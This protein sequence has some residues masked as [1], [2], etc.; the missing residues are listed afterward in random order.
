VT[1]SSSLHTH[2]VVVNGKTYKTS[3]S[4][5]THTETPVPSTGVVKAFPATGTTIQFLAALADMSIDVL[6]LAA[7]TYVWSSVYINVDRTARPLIVRPA[8]GAAVAFKSSSGGLFY[9]GLGGTAKYLDFEF[10]GVTFDGY[11]L[12]STGLV[13]MGNADHITFNGPTVQNCVATGDPINSWALY[14]SVD[15]GLSPT[16][17]VADDWTVKGMSRTVSALQVG[18]PPSTLGHVYARRW[19][20]D[21]VSYAV[22]AYGTATDLQLDG[23]TVTN[24][25]RADRPYTVFFGAA[26]FGTFSNMNVGT[27]GMESQGGMVRGSGNVGI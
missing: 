23:W 27:G 16:N 12:G 22:Y 26:C 10:A 2:T 9:F 20:V 11:S 21:S 4:T 5:H 6:E 13:W 15:A 3:S 25:V 19:T 24:S 7:G 8:A 14:L 1:I 18:H 17:I